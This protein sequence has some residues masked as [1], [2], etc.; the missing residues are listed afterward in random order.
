MCRPDICQL[1][2]SLNTPL[3]S[4][5]A[6]NLVHRKA[7]LTSYPVQTDCCFVAEATKLLLWTVF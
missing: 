2:D 7:R 1:R 4:T 5:K 3:G 6:G